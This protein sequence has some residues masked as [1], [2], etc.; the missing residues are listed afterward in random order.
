MEAVE[1]VAAELAGAV[2]ARHVSLLV[3]NMS[4]TAL[5]RLSHVEPGPE[6]VAGHNERTDSVPLAGSPYER[7]LFSQRLEVTA[8]GDSWRVL[9]P[10]TERGDA[11]GVLEV[12][13]P[14]PPDAEV[15]EFLAGA[16]HAFAYCLVAAR[17][18][19][20]LFEW[21]QRDVAFSVPAEIQRRLLPPAYTVEGGPFTLAGWL[22]PAHDVGG[23][24]FDYSVGREYLYAS[25]TD[26]MGHSTRAALL[27][28][29]AVAALRNVRR[30]LA[31]PT[32]QADAANAELV[33]HAGGEQFVTGLVLR[34]GLGD[35]RVELV[36]AGHPSPYLVRSGQPVQL[37]LNGGLPLGLADDAYRAQRFQLQAGDRLLLVTDGY[38][39]RNAARVDIPAIL[40]A[41]IDRHPRQIVQELA[42]R[43]LGATGGKLRD[44]A[45]AMCMDWHGPD[46]PRHATAGATRARTTPT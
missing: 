19:T 45:T 5:V 26:A 23:D 36:N 14:A 33:A 28:T 16:A 3:T 29:L 38:L 25:L 11:L 1:V 46:N 2:G 39:E 37:P 7:V 24:T 18:H 27:A 20:D 21:A 43:L 9:V 31:G 15:G 41:T 40:A 22:E 17:R 12:S 42:T 35:G 13:L 6:W 34:V 10:V 44:D 4:G 30:D 32:D 8:K